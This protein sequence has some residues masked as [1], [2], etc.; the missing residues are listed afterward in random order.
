MYDY[1]EMLDIHRTTAR[2]RL[3]R[4]KKHFKELKNEE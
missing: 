4:I 1:C 3:D 2:R